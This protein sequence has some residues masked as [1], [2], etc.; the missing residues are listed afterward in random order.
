VRFA[1]ECHDESGQWKRAC[2]N[3]SWE[4]DECGLMRIRH[5]SINDVAIDFSQHKFFWDRS[6]PRPLDHAGLSEFN[7]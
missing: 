4:F 7:F 5:A 6:R 1:Y 3:E 2:G